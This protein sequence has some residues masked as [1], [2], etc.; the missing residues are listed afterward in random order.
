M[1]V[2]LTDVLQ[3]VAMRFKGALHIPQCLPC[4]GH[5]AAFNQCKRARP[6]AH[7]AGKV[8][9]VADPD[10]FRERQARACK[11][12]RIEVFDTRGGSGFGE[13]M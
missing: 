13:V 11:F 4:L 12:G 2:H 7:L 10:D 1:T 6:C 8:Q 9:H 5:H 3:A